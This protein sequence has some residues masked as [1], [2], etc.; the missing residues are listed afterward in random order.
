MVVP[1]QLVVPE[2]I[3]AAARRMAWPAALR[4]TRAVARDVARV[5]VVVAQVEEAAAWEEAAAECQEEA[6]SQD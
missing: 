3:Q 5:V 6:D 1:E 2:R 4:A